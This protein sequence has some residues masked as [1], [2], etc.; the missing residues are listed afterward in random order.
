MDRF[1]DVVSL[2][3]RVAADQLQDDMGPDD[4]EG[5]DSMTH[6]ILFTALEEAFSVT[7]DTDEIPSL[8]TI[9]AIRRALDAKRAKAA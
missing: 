8:A 4:I 1:E 9:G 5:W 3:F 2:T 7:F 6:L